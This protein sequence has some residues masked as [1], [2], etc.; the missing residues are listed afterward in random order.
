MPIYLYQCEKCGTKL[1]IRQGIHEG[2]PPCCGVAM[3]KVPT[4]PSIIRTMGTNK[5]RTYSKGYKQG[6]SKDYLKSMS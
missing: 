5:T 2:I 1:E 6:Y 3:K 4:A